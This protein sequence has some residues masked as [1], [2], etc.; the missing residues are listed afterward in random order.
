MHPEKQVGCTQIVLFSH[1]FPRPDGSPVSSVVLQQNSSSSFSSPL[2][3]SPV[4]ITN[5]QLLTSFPQ[6]DSLHLQYEL[7]SSANPSRL[8][9]NPHPSSCF[10]DP[11]P[12][13]ISSSVTGNC[14][15]LPFLSDPTLNGWRR[16][17]PLIF[18]LPPLPNIPASNTSRLSLWTHQQ[19]WSAK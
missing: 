14:L 11:L 10:L 18:L 15:R 2:P 1:C 7:E 8:K 12:S 3:T 17:S 13:R 19:S 5:H 16:P 6:R 4:D 9:V